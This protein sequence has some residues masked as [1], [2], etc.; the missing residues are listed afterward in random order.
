MDSNVQ[1]A[2]HAQNRNQ[3]SWLWVVLCAV[4]IFS[5]IPIARSLQK[6]VY[7]YLGKEFFTYI[8]LFVIVCGLVLLLYYFIFRLNINRFSQYVWLIS[9]AAVLIYVTIQLNE[10]PEEAIHLL[11]YGLLAYFTYNAL[12]Y[13]IQDR[14]VYI[15]AILIVASVGA[16]DEFI[17]WM[18]PSRVWDYKDV[19]INTLAG[20]FPLLA[21][22]KGIKPKIIG[23]PIK[24]IS[25]RILVLAATINLIL[26]SI[27]V[28]NTPQAV[29]SYTSYFENLSWL[30][31]EETMTEFGNEYYDAEIGFIQTRI[32][33]E[34]I[35]K[36]DLNNGE[37]FGRHLIQK[38]N[39][40]DVS[41]NLFSDEVYKRLKKIYT[42][43]T[44]LFL[45]EFLSHV[46]KRDIEFREFKD[47]NDAESRR[48]AFKENQI[49]EK[50]FTNTL[51]NSGLI[52]PSHRLESLGETDSLKRE[53][54][55]SRTG[56][57]ITFISLKTALILIVITL[58]VIWVSGALF[59]QKL[60]DD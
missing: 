43:N 2:Y 9:C 12:S 41:R 48:E 45:Y 39:L 57:I 17:Q 24:K 56:R 1:S 19:G 27:C 18:T 7:N 30:R 52:W 37:T 46:S 16:I 32:T 15:T 58:V 49:V 60:N 36:I 11:E 5:T 33:L 26:L 50:Y 40:M 8:V 10:H 31:S 51:K 44:N 22:C 4:T 6:F 25:V 3:K 59:I 28:S 29:Q 54:Y 21:V 35:I 34:E 55:T 47:T 23:R 20:A 13:R 38:I 42:R 53:S 14:S